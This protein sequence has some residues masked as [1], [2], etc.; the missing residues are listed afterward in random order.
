LLAEARYAK[1]REAIED[2]IAAARRRDPKDA[3]VVM[4]TENGAEEI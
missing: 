1:R 3:N 4:V 2:A